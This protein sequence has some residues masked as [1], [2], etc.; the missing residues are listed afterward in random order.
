[1]HHYSE[2]DVR[3][4]G[5]VQSA[6][7]DQPQNRRIIFKVKHIEQQDLSYFDS[8]NIAL[9]WPES[10]ERIAAGQ[11]WELQVSIRPAHGS[12]NQGGFNRQRW[13]ISNHQILNGYVKSSQLI[14]R[15][16]SLR[17][18]FIDKSHDI[19]SS[20]KYSDILFALAFGERGLIEPQQ[21][22]LLLKTGIAHL[23][24]ISGLH[25]SLAAMLGFI[26]ARAAQWLLPQR[27]INV[28]FPYLCGWLFAALYTW[29]SGINPPAVRALMALT[30][31]LGLKR[32]CWFLSPWQTWL[33]IVTLLLIYDP[34]MA[35]S[36]SV[37]LSCGAVAGLI[38]WFQWLPLKPIF[39]KKR[40]LLVRLLHLQLAMSFLLI[41][42]QILIFQGMSLNSFFCNLIAVPVVSYITVPAVLIA[43]AFSY[44]PFISEYLWSVANYSLSVIFPILESLQ[45]N[46]LNIAH[47]F[48]FLA[49]VSWC[50]GLSFT[51]LN[52]GE[53]LVLLA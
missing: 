25:I 41:P 31:W 19:M 20:L 22:Q 27:L 26:I 6:S 16:L 1:M 3:L 53:N 49:I 37:W 32:Y 29:L 36:D 51:V 34:L 30:L 47:S 33:Y 48:V 15:S 52:C 44:I 21:R 13:A 14:D 12:L 4:I 2:R 39:L 7:I 5:I 46:W 10:S 50:F 11:K 43:I 45:Y 40:W 35:L 17:Q 38:F 9:N 28:W 18:Q 42:L 8:F 23:M 24:A